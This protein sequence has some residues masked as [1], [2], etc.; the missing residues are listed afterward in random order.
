MNFKD[1]LFEEQSNN[2]QKFTVDEK[3]KE[4]VIYS[5]IN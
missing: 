3:L 5:F 1:T 2:R 4:N